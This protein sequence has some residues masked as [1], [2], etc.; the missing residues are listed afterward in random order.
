MPSTPW[1]QPPLRL[2]VL[3]AFVYGLSLS[4]WDFTKSL[5]IHLHSPLLGTSSR[6]RDL[7]RRRSGVLEET[8]VKGVIDVA[9]NF[10]HLQARFYS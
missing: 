3:S 10:G 4:K 8:Y 9:L 2:S 7:A 1:R 5:L 6:Q